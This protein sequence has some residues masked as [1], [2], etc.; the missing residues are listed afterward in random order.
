MSVRLAAAFTSVIPV[1]ATAM[2]TTILAVLLIVAMTGDV[3]AECVITSLDTRLKDADIV[4]L[5]QVD[6]IR[7]ISVDPAE[8]NIIN[9]TIVR[10]TVKT[11]WKGSTP[12]QIELRQTTSPEE[13]NFWQLIGKDLVL[14]VRR[15]TPERPHWAL[16]IK[17]P[18]TSG[19]TVEPCS[20]PE[21][22]DLSVFGKGRSPIE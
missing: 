21:K 15:L 7:G 8:P 1:V 3:Y 14:F 11:L 16:N 13:P 5:A 12:R 10:L 2:R 17:P 22:M 4:M 9:G 19:Y 18:L 20:V 6:G